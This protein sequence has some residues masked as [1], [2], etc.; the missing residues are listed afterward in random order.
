MFI[1]LFLFFTFSFF[2]FHNTILINLYLDNYEKILNILIVDYNKMNLML[3]PKLQIASYNCI[4][5]F[6]CGQIKFNKYLRPYVHQLFDK[7]LSFIGYN[8]TPQFTPE[9]IYSFYN[10]GNVV[11]FEKYKNLP[12]VK[13]EQFDLFVMSKQDYNQ[14]NDTYISNHICSQQIIENPK[15]IESSIKFLNIILIYNNKEYEIKLKDKYTY[16]NNNY[17][18][19]DNILDCAFFKYYISD[20]QLIKNIDYNNFKY[21]LRILDHNVNS[22]ELDETQAIVILKDSYEIININDIKP[23]TTHNLDANNA[24]TNYIDNE[25]NFEDDFDKLE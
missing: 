20:N 1:Y 14:N 22:V 21:K 16:N 3:K 19:I 18:I 6:S 12:I 13:P 25:D 11:M 4:Y 17:Y 7:F 8:D 9:I 2:Y 24:D 15:F 23:K 5:Y 10:N